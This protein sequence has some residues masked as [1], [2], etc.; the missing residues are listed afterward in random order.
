MKQR[1]IRKILFQLLSI[2]LS[3]IFFIITNEH[4]SFLVSFTTGVKTIKQRE[5]RRIDKKKSSYPVN[6]Y[7]RKI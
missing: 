4:F 3:P 5:I 1:E 7:I 2:S 6:G